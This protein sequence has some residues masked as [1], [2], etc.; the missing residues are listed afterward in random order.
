MRSHLCVFNTSPN[1]ALSISFP[2]YSPKAETG[3]LLG[4]W[5]IRVPRELSW[6]A[7]SHAHDCYLHVC[8]D[9]CLEL[10]MQG[11]LKGVLSCLE[12]PREGAP[13]ADLAPQVQENKGSSE[14]GVPGCLLSFA[15]LAK[16]VLALCNEGRSLE[17][18]LCSWALSQQRASGCL[19]QL[20]WHKGTPGV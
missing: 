7:F 9:T 1:L 13:T 8:K 14:P 18:P 19:H 2:N 4:V 20:C 17:R 10:E 6:F 15:A 11:A 3:L 5:L 16:A 12:P